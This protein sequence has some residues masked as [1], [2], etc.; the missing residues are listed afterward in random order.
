M[1]IPKRRLNNWIESYLHF[2]RHHLAIEEFHL[3]TGLGILSAAI[4]RNRWMDLGYYKAFPNLFLLFIG[5]SGIGKSSSSGIGMKI[6]R[7][8]KLPL[9]VYSDS[10]TA[11]SLVDCMSLSVV[12]WEAEGK[13]HHKTPLMVYASEIGTLLTQRNSVLELATILT[14]LFSKDDDYENRTKSG[15]K[16]II[17]NPCL[18][19]FACCVS[20]WLDENI[21]SIA[22]KMGFLGRML[23]VTASKKRHKGGY[24]LDAVDATLR[25]DLIH[26]LRLISE[27]YGEMAFDKEAQVWWDEWTDTL[28]L[29]V[30]SNDAIEVKGFLSRK[31]QH[32]RKLAM[33]S[34]IS[35]RDSK[36][37]ISKDGLMFGLNLLERCEVNAKGLGVTPAHA[38]RS[39]ILRD[40]I[41]K[42][43]KKK[44]D[45]I[46]PI[47]EIMP[48]VYRKMTTQEVEEGINTLCSI[49]FCKL[50]GRKIEVLDQKIGT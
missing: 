2:T 7:E 45:N 31:E 47:R 24:K 33:L 41:L 36:S 37:L 21:N 6:L 38:M 39:D 17:K 40:T 25:D 50:V 18:M 28:P 26:D 42:L 15:G 35:K 23:I 14:E 48:Y 13:V 10:L 20:E 1:T 22:L 9:Q 43:S 5:P 49:G 8:A 3:W 29:E 16:T 19:F 44:K 4:N 32:V 27:L 34:A 46:V 12:T 11:A 30:V